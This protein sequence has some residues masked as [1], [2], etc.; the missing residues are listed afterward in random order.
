MLHIFTRR[1]LEELKVYVVI[2]C[3][4]AGYNAAIKNSSLSPP[5]T[6]SRLLDIAVV[7]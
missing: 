5:M 3:D 4:M 7:A 2:L 6:L 1:S